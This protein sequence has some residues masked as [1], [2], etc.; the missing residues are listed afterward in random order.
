[1]LNPDQAVA[2]LKTLIRGT[3]GDRL[4]GLYLHG[5]MT[6]GD[7]DPACSDLDLLAVLPSDPTETECRRL[8]RMHEGFV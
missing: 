1:M 4:V 3:L 2:E 5:S 8:R 7:F 6:C